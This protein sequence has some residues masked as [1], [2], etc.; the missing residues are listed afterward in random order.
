M[1]PMIDIS[2]ICH[3]VNVEIKNN[4][5]EASTCTQQDMH[6]VFFGFIKRNGSG[7]FETHNQIVMFHNLLQVV[8][9]F[10]VGRNFHK[11]A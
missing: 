7:N 6:M 1:Y 5:D 11:P 9:E 8:L 3:E 10:A 2:H 4:M